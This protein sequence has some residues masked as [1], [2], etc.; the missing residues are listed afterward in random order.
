MGKRKRNGTA[1]KREGRGETREFKVVLRN[2]E[3]IGSG[4][5]GAGGRDGIGMAGGLPLN[6][7]GVI[8][9]AVPHASHQP[10][11]QIHPP[12]FASLLSP[13]TA[14]PPKAKTQPL[15]TGT[16]CR[17]TSPAMALPHLSRLRTLPARSGSGCC[18]W[19]WRSLLSAAA[20]AAAAT[21]GAAASAGGARA[22]SLALRKGLRMTAAAGAAT[23][24]TRAT[25]RRAATATARDGRMTEFG[26]RSVCAVC[27]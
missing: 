1:A 18:C 16:F 20:A 15:P 7:S 22:S 17:F 6:Q 19:G 23:A 8:G 11:P 25:A 3:N 10:T 9:G 13:P 27:L 5:E 24:A 26:V 4:E 21:T 12:P 14:P 2:K